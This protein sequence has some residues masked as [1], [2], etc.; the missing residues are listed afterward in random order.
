M[1]KRARTSLFFEEK[2][3][4]QFRFV[5][6]GPGLS[7]AVCSETLRAV[8]ALDPV[9][10]Y[11]IASGSLPQGV[12]ADFYAHVVA[13]GRRASSR[14]VVDTSGAALAGA[15]EA[16]P[17]MIKPSLRELRELTGASLENEGAMV[18]VGRRLIAEGK[19]DAIALT[20]GEDGA[21]LFTGDGAWRANAPKVEISSAVGA[22]DSFVGGMI[23]ALASG[24]KM[25]DAFRRG[26][27]AGSAALLSAGTELCHPKDAE[28]L[29][30]EVK[31]RKIG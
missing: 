30:D 6:P 2:S 1:R 5:M 7:A 12:P 24:E 4:N 14:V 15:L 13:A 31:A 10:D 19:A 8:S 21:V 29:F 9:P 22:G 26:V 16:R 23:G 27:A 17:F 20:L 3:G 11:L 18:E 28:R 25:E